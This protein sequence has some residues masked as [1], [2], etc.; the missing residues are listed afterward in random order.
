MFKI[1][2]A[3]C[4]FASISKKEILVS[5]KKLQATSTA[6]AALFLE[7]NLRVLIW[8]VYLRVCSSSP[9]TEV[10]KKP[11]F[12]FTSK[13]ISMSKLI[14]IIIII[15]TFRAKMK[16]SCIDITL[17]TSMAFFQDCWDVLKDDIMKVFHDSHDRGKFER[18]LN[19]NFIA[20]I[21]KILGVVNHKDFE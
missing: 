11:M 6:P 10:S 5:L 13:S 9:H 20:L 16:F 14:I 2:L 17:K 18:R 1:T 15:F 19:I 4:F 21:P 8:N 3:N 12:F 7:Y